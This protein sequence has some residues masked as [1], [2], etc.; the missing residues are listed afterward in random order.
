MEKQFYFLQ[1][2]T[3]F[4]SIW[5]IDMTLSDATTLG[6]SGPRRDSNERVLCILQSFSITETS[7][8]D[9]L[10]DQIKKYDYTT[11]F[12]EISQRLHGDRVNTTK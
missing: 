10:D 7:S 8:S 12:Y 3:Q 4:S 11:G 6:Q 2:R 5:P 9:C 1:F